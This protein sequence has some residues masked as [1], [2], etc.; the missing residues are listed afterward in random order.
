MRHGPGPE[1]AAGGTRGR[2]RLVG[3]ASLYRRPAARAAAPL[4][5]KAVGQFL[6][7]P[8]ELVAAFVRV[9]P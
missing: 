3:V 1:V 8:A 6:V 2:G 4:D 5:R 7:R 9:N